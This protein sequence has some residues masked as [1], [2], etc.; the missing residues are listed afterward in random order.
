MA[1]V[2]SAPARASK[3]ES[4]VDNKRKDDIRMSNIKSARSVAD[5]VRT[6]L[7][8]KGMD[9]MIS[10]ASGDVIITNDGATILNKM[11]VL[12]PAA[13]M[14]VELSKSQDVVAGDGTT[15]VVVI[16]GALLKQC[17]T[18]L[19]SV[20][21]PNEQKN[22]DE[23]I[24]AVKD[25]NLIEEGNE[26][27]RG[28]GDNLARNEEEWVEDGIHPTVIS[29]SLH[30]ASVKAVDVLTAMAVPVELT[31]RDSLVKSASTSLNSKVVSQYSSLLAPL[32]VD[33]VLAVVDP[34]KPDLVDLRDVK[35]VKKLGGTVDDTELVKGLVFD[36]K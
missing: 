21:L 35:I 36:K 6:S 9:K 7:G 29:D 32:A 22:K 4:Y 12:Q 3:V 30:K 33:S 14:L 5:A 8:P 2:A 17:Q 26:R 31:D 28:G 16:A 19:H 13:K 20:M 15:T 1:A 23:K 27:R 11:E 25:K 18:L 10:T 34:A 24:P